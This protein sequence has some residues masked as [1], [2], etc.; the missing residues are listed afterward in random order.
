MRGLCQHFRVEHVNVSSDLCPLY[1]TCS[2]I[3]ALIYT[4]GAACFYL[5]IYRRTA[6][7]T[8]CSC[9]YPALTVTLCRNEFALNDVSYD[10]FFKLLEYLYT[11]E[12]S[13]LTIENLAQVGRGGSWLVA[14]CCT[15]C[16][17]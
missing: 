16:V 7:P 12:I 9:P 1:L 8:H 10:A 13:Q 5:S 17:L 6:H 11:G 3:V 4:F 2:V 15:H 14:V